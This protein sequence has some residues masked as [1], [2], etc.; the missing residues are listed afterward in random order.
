MIQE[1]IA[2]Q[3]GTANNTQSSQSSQKKIIFGNIL[4]IKMNNFRRK[5]DKP[6]YQLE[7]CNNKCSNFSLCS[8]TSSNLEEDQNPQLKVTSSSTKTLTA[9]STSVSSSSETPLP[10]II[11]PQPIVS[12]SVTSFSDKG[13]IKPESTTNSWSKSSSLF[14]HFPW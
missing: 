6:K 13:S 7:E 10:I 8:N 9:S 5:S 14:S 4:K 11:E 2:H 1:T 12:T 3:D